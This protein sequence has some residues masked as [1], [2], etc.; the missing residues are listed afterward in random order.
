LSGGN[1]P[2]SGSP[3]S[4]RSPPITLAYPTSITLPFVTFSTMRNPS[5]K[6]A[7]SRSTDGVAASRIGAVARRGAG[8]VRA[9]PIHSMRPSRYASSGYADGTDTSRFAAP[10]N[11]YET[12][13]A[14]STARSRCSIRSGGRRK[15]AT[16]RTHSPIHT[17]GA[18]TA[19]PN[20]PGPPRAIVQA[21]CGPVQ[22]SSTRPL[23]SPTMACTISSL[24]RSS[25]GGT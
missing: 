15:G 23:R 5:R 7:P 17:H 16:K 2:Y 12:E 22:T 24:R 10:K 18:L 11:A 8:R 6:T 25:D 1:A 4:R 21:T 3:W 9:K 14:S 13:N 19:R 20:W